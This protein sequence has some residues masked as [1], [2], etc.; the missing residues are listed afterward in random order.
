MSDQEVLP[1]LDAMPSGKRL[2]PKQLAA[3]SGY[4]LG[5]LARLRAGTQGPP[6]EKPGHRSILY[7]VGPFR[8]WRDKQATLRGTIDDPRLDQPA[9][10][11]GESVRSRLQAGGRRK[12][13]AKAA[14]RSKRGG[15]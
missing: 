10:E 15:Q 11:G 3:A 12:H 2:T 4:S 13:R 14:D 7:I 1:D 8:E 5:L 9:K 6:Y